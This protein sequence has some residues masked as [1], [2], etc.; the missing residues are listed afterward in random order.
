MS[1]L[2]FFLNVLTVTGELYL[3]HVATPMLTQQGALGR[4]LRHVCRSI[5]EGGGGQFSCPLFVLQRK[6]PPPGA[7]R[8]GL[9]AASALA[10]CHLSPLG[11]VLHLRGGSA[12]HGPARHSAPC[13]TNRL[14]PHEPPSIILEAAEEKLTSCIFAAQDGD[15]K[16]DAPPTGRKRVHDVLWRLVISPLMSSGLM[17]VMI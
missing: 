1:L 17:I 7:L 8:N 3:P 11:I 14:R 12:G 4:N 13:P 16:R 9:A 10:C 15:I 5:R 6:C 2:T